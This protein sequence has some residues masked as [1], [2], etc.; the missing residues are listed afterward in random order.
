MTKCCRS[1]RWPS[2][3]E[4][5]PQRHSC[6]TSVSKRIPTRPWEASRHPYRVPRSTQARW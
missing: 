4:G 1:R 3:S 6:V 5:S 2:I